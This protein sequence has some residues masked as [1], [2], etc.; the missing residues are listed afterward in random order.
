MDVVPNEK[1]ECEISYN[2]IDYPEIIC[3]QLLHAL[4]G[5]G[6]IEATLDGVHDV[7]HCAFVLLLLPFKDA[8]RRVS[9]DL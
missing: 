7:F 6:G 8:Q 5:G 9:F 2:Q 4:I 1:V 3:F